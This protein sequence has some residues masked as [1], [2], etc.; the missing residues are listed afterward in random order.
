MNFQE[1][2]ATAI[3]HLNDHYLPALDAAG[4]APIADAIR[5]GDFDAAAS[6]TIENMHHPLIDEYVKAIGR[7]LVTPEFLD[8][9]RA[10]E[11]LCSSGQGETPEAQAASLQMFKTAPE[12]FLDECGKFLQELDLLPPVSGYTADGRPTYRVN[13]IADK[14]GKTPNEVRDRADQL[15]LSSEDP[16]IHTVQ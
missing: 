11:A 5:A 14:L 10:Y 8:A 15:G 6:A 16:P 13:D 1:S 12:W 2:T 9:G 7:Q 3:D 4:F